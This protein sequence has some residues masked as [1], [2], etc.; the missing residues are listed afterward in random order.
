MSNS[1]SSGEDNGK[2]FQ[3]GFNISVSGNPSSGYQV[4]VNDQKQNV[5]QLAPTS[6]L[7]LMPSAGMFIIMS[8]F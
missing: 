4:M 1:D 3:V 2:V 8:I 6:P 5:N 7:P